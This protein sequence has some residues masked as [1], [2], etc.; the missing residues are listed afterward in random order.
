M[1]IWLLSGELIGR[2]LIHVHD[3]E[4]C[5]SLRY[6]LLFSSLVLLRPETFQGDGTLDGLQ[7]SLMKLQEPLS[8]EL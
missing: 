7:A 8:C 3:A 4:H 2:R 1:G 5:L 6:S